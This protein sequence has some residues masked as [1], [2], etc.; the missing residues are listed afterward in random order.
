MTYNGRKYSGSTTVVVGEKQEEKEYHFAISVLGGSEEYACYSVDTNIPGY[1]RNQTVWSVTPSQGDWFQD[2][3]GF[4]YV[5]RAIDCTITA[6][7]NYKKP[8]GSFYS[9]TYTQTAKRT[10]YTFGIS[11]VSR[12]VEVGRA[13]FTINT[14]IPGCTN[15]NVT[16]NVVSEHRGGGLWDGQY[17]TVDEFGMTNGE[18]YVLNASYVYDGRT[19]TASCTVTCTW[20]S[21]NA[22]GHSLSEI[23]TDGWAGGS[24]ASGFRTEI[25]DCTSAA[26]PAAPD[27]H[28][29]NYAARSHRMY[30]GYPN[31]GMRP[32]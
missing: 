19:Y 12:D 3:D 13:S 30:G 6:L 17:Y 22:D 21:D 4:L 2:T 29:R 25:P 28:S 7:Y 10:E 24:A 26:V 8:D 11:L 20:G 5:N 14:T 27:R 15:N 18:S 1:Q 16:W 32:L 31:T 23:H 9:A